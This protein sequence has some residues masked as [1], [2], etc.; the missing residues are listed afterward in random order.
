MRNQ[1]AREKEKINKCIINQNAIGKVQKALLAKRI[2]SRINWGNQSIRLKIM[3]HALFFS[4]LGD[5]SVEMVYEDNCYHKI[6]SLSPDDD[7]SIR[8]LVSFFFHS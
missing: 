6:P 5:A 3:F 4:V 1:K 7:R 8:A 2:M